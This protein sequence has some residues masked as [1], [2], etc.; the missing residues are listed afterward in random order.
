MFPEVVEIIIIK[1][2]FFFL[3]TRIERQAC[4]RDINF[5]IEVSLSEP[6]GEMGDTKTNRKIKNHQ[7]DKETMCTSTDATTN[8]RH[9]NSTD[10]DTGDIKH[11]TDLTNCCS[12]HDKTTTPSTTPTSTSTN[13]DNNDNIMND[14]ST[15]SLIPANCPVLLAA[16]AAAASSGGSSSDGRKRVSKACLECKK[17]HCRCD[18]QRPCGRCAKLGLECV[19]APTCKRYGNNFCFFLSETQTFFHIMCE[20]K[21]KQQQSVECELTPE[22]SIFKQQLQQTEV[23]PRGRRTRRENVLSMNHYALIPPR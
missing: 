2:R 12:S 21:T 13:N 17:R 8:Q 15:N 22:L 5:L 9:H 6:E 14:N 10:T 3:T 4:Y 7:N 19:D 23:R 16:A 18:H 11:N 20:S 1:C